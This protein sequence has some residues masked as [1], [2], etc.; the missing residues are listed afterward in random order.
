[1]L[2][3]FENNGNCNMNV[4]ATRPSRNVPRFYCDILLQ[5]SVNVAEQQFVCFVF[6]IF[7]FA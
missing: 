2:Y 7:I 4:N 3:P 5:K 6:S 1:M